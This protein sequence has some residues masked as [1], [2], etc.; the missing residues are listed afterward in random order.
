MAQQLLDSNYIANW[1]VE[2]ILP[3]CITVTS[4][5]IQTRDGHAMNTTIQNNSV[6]TIMNTTASHRVSVE[7]IVIC[8]NL[9]TCINKYRTV[10]PYVES[11]F[12]INQPNS[13]RKILPLLLPYTV[14]SQWYW[15][16]VK[17]DTRR[18]FTKMSYNFHFYLKVQ[19]NNNFQWRTTCFSVQLLSESSKEFCRAEL[20]WTNVELNE[21][22]HDQ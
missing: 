8:H 16:P 20:C 11:K 7:I 5:I 4:D 1:N 22:F 6:L 15:V 14:H 9:W 17:F 18:N 19:V 12:K 10:F 3:N 21:I 2:Q 13:L